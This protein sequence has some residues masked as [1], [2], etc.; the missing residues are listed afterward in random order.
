MEYY[1]KET[2]SS[3]KNE[4]ERIINTETAAGAKIVHIWSSQINLVQILFA[5]KTK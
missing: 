3:D 2:F 5:R 4:L 1:I